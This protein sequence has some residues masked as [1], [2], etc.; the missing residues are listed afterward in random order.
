VLIQQSRL[1]EN[2]TVTD[3][4]F[5]PRAINNAGQVAG[6]GANSAAF[7]QNGTMTDLGVLGGTGSS[8]ALAIGGAGQ[9]V[10]SSSTATG[11][12]HAFLW[13][14]GTMTDL[15]TLGGDF[16]EAVAV[17]DVGQVIGR[18]S[19]SIFSG[20]DRGFSW[21]NG[22]MTDLGTLGGTF[23]LVSAINNAGQ[24]VGGS[25]TGNG[26]EHAFL[27]HNGT[28][29]DLNALLP[30]GAG[31]VLYRATLIN[32][33]GQIVAVGVNSSTGRGSTFLLTP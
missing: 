18:S 32:D 3:L 25:T 8:M 1:W 33:A 23:T 17:N 31:V 4:G 7:W 5:G 27:W 11:K 28:M 10:G 21:Q 26:T 22:T 9:V 19:T 29:T 6:N 14:N 12:T 20:A 16:S 2:G 15:G 24:V 13:Q 30:P